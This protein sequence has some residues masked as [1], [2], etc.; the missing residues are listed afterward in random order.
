LGQASVVP[1]GGTSPYTYQWI[2]GGNNPNDSLNTGMQAGTYNLI[3]TDANGCDTINNNIVITEPPFI[4]LTVSHTDVSCN[5]LTDGTATVTATG[6]TVTN[7]YLY[8]WDS[9]AGN[10]TTQTA[11][12]LGAGTYWVTVQDDNGCEESISV[13]INEPTPLLFNNM[14][15]TDLTCYMSSDGTINSGATGGTPGYT[16]NWTNDIPPYTWSSTQQNLTSLEAGTYSLTVTDGN[17]CTIDTSI[18]LTQP[19]QLTISLTVTDESCANLCDGSITTTVNGGTPPGGPYNYTWNQNGVFFSSSQNLTN[20]CVGQYDVTVTD[21]N[22]CTITSNETITGPNPLLITINSVNDATC[23]ST[24]GAIDISFSGGTGVPSVLWS[25]GQTTEDITGISAGNYCVSVTDAN[26]CETDTCI[27]VSNIG[28]PIINGFTVN[29]VTCNGNSNGWISADTSHPSSPALPYTIVWD[30]GTNTIGAGNGGGTDSIYGLPGG[31]Y[32]ITITDN[33]GCFSIGNASINEPSQVTVNTGNI[34]DLT[35]NGVCTGYASA[36]GGGGVGGYSYSWSNGDL[37]A[38]ASNLCAGIHSVTVTDGNGCQAVGTATVQEPAPLVINLDYITDALC[39][40][41]TDGAISVSP[42][43]GSGSYAYNWLGQGV[44]TSV[45]GNIGQGTY[46]VVVSDQN[47]LTCSTDSS[48]TVNEPLPITATT[49]TESTT[50]GNP[51]GSATIVGVSGGTSPYNYVW[52][53]CSG[54]CNGATLNNLTSGTYQVQV[55]D[56]HGCSEVFSANVGDIPPPYVNNTD[57]KDVSCN[58]GNDGVATVM[59]NDGTSPYSYNWSPYGGPDST[60]SN[61]MAGTYTVTVTDANGCETYTSFSI[62]EP[63]PVIVYGDG[64]TTP[65]CIGMLANISANAAGGTAPYTYSWNSGLDSTQIHQVYP[66]T[67]TTYLVGAVDANGCTSAQTSITVEV[68]PPITVNSSPDANICEADTQDITASATGGNGGPYTYIWNI[69]SG[70]PNY[71]S[72]TQT[73]TYTVYANDACGSPSDTAQTTVFVRPAPYLIT[74]LQGYSGCEPLSVSYSPEV[75]SVGGNVSYLWNFGDIGSS[76]NTSNLDS[77]SHEYL[78]SG[79][80]SVM[81]TLTSDYQCSK[82]YV[83]N[84]LVRVYPNPNG[85]FFVTPEV[86]GL[87]DPEVNFY[88][89]TTDP[90][91]SWYWNFGDNST[92]TIQ[93]PT[94]KYDAAGE[95]EIEL[96]VRTINGC[97]DTVYHTVQ[98]NE[99]HT[100][101]APTAFTPGAGIGNKYFYPKGVGI[102]KG[103][104]QL[105]VYDRWGQIIYQ[106]NKCPLGTDKL[107]SVEGGWNGRYNNTGEYV[108][109]GTYLW[110]VNLVDVNGV[111]H[112]YKGTVVIMR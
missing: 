89:L 104:Y 72:P 25:S 16:F 42:S 44:N 112:E 5:S 69:G 80:Y 99:E 54:N 88:D 51:N 94:H 22:G 27:G 21:N 102:D 29:D 56:S 15:S 62:G 57:V 43:G 34:Q 19:F 84:N 103:Q 95:Y 35:C 28:G 1:I 81:L 49:T 68:Y 50:C 92:A 45:I 106:S 74:D 9:N 36:A 107:E 38:T 71:V 26:A 59:I 70:N 41:T 109:E 65:I 13:T 111:P 96:I 108:E 37:T 78:T 31:N 46:T 82:N 60:S 55:F 105:T 14:S 10:Q 98:V 8:I 7:D 77:V 75:D 52:S 17:G 79:N 100:F 53:P 64:P 83:Y 110:K 12:G 97:V 48:F 90:I 73:T 32:T 58:G 66:T 11:T 6:G 39:N 2:G 61:L 76:N 23:G 63:T 18:I 86:V 3:I 87:F 93:N 91:A 101:Y 24:N 67:T 85:E 30:D 47:D 20:L 4:S 40:G 33:N